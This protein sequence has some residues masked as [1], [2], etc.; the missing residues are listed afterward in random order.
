MASFLVLFDLFKQPPTLCKLKLGAWL[1]NTDFNRRNKADFPN[2]Y[3]KLG[4][5]TIFEIGAERLPWEEI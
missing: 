3:I 4:E 1:L 5:N 2:C